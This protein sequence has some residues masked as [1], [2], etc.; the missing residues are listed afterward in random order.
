MHPNGTDWAYGVDINCVQSCPRPL[1]KAVKAHFIL[2]VNVLQFLIV[3]RV[4]NR[5]KYKL[6]KS[7][8][9]TIDNALQFVYINKCTSKTLEPF[10][11]CYLQTTFFHKNSNKPF[12]LQYTNLV[13]LV[14]KVKIMVILSY[15]LFVFCNRTFLCAR[16]WRFEDY[17]IKSHIQLLTS[18]SSYLSKEK[19]NWNIL[20]CTNN[21]CCQISA[22]W[23]C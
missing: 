21:N 19:K 1:W 3:A 11:G 14:V 6:Y 16:H 2:R 13:Q 7:S 18:I 8:L 4:L 23:H 12:E 5:K 17:I 9:K 22:G 10:K 20:F 15:L